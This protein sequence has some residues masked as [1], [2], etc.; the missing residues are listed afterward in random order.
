MRGYAKEAATRSRAT[1]ATQK[2][3]RGLTRSAPELDEV[4]ARRP[5]AARRSHPPTE[6]A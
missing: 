2:Q 3:E 6:Q 4:Q 1:A 5:A